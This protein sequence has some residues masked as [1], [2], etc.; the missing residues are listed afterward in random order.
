MNRG[1]ISDGR[2][3][4]SQNRPFDA[5]RYFSESE[6]EEKENNWRSTDLWIFFGKKFVVMLHFHFISSSAYAAAILRLLLKYIPG[7]SSE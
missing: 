1:V 5:E 4:Y 2:D 6:E 3:S 7:V